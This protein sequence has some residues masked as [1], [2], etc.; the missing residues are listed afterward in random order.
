MVHEEVQVMVVSPPPIGIWGETLTSTEPVPLTLSVS[1]GLSDKAIVSRTSVA[2]I[3]VHVLWVLKHP[4]TPQSTRYVSFCGDTV[5]IT[6]EPGA[7]GALQAAPQ[8]SP[9][10]LEVTVALPDPENDTLSVR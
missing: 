7:K 3:T 6:V 10:G 5:R 4:G 8:L 2:I 9:A 1:V